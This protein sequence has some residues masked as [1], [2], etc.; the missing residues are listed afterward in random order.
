MPTGTLIF[1]LFVAIVADAA[2]TVFVERLYNSLR[3]ELMA[4]KSFCIEVWN[5]NE[6]IVEAAERNESYVVE[7]GSPSPRAFK[8]YFKRRE[9]S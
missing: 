4:A 2:Y 9:P 3:A 1:L 8:D 7:R 5:L 6:E